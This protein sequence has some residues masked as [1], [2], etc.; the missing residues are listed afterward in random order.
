LPP[1]DV[2]IEL[3]TRDIDDAPTREGP[4]KWLK[5]MLRLVQVAV[6]GH[7]VVAP[8]IGEFLIA[9]AVHPTRNR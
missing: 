7:G 1:L 2:L 6:A 3:G 8:Q 9:D 5:T 4:I